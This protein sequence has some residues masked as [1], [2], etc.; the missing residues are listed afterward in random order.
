MIVGAAKSN[1]WEELGLLIMAP[2]NHS[3]ASNK[4]R[5]TYSTASSPMRKIKISAREATI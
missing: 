4:K 5:T 2:L 3:P 1:L